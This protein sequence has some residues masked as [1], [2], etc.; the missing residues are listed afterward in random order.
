M[1]KNNSV[2]MWIVVILAVVASITYLSSREDTSPTTTADDS[3]ASE[4]ISR[5]GLHWHP[6][7]A[8]YVQGEKIEIPANIGLIGTHNPIHTHDE[9]SEQGIIHMEFP[10]L[11]RGSNT[12][13]DNF[14]KAWKKDINSFGSNMSMTVNGVENTEF[15]DYYMKDGDTIELRYE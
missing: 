9:D 6:E 10:A 14:F 4:M 11:V 12:A 5:N 2:F 7:L 8:I 3:Y 13:L 1:S 15:G